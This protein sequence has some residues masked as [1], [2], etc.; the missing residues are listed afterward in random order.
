MVDKWVVLKV[1]PWAEE[2]A[3]CLA[4]QTAF[5][6]VDMSADLKVA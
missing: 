4:A 2:M 6:T 1:D 3:H 5:Q